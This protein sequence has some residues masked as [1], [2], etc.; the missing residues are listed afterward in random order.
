[1]AKT[2]FR[3]VGTALVTP[4]SADGSVDYE[5]LKELTEVQIA[6]GVN[7]I[8]ACGTTGE[9]STLRHDEHLKVIETIITTSAGRVPV[10]A[11][12]GSNDTLYTLELSEA[13]ERMGADALLMV[14]PYYNKTSQNGL[15]RHYEYVADRVNTPIILYNVPSR[16]G[17]DIKPETY[18]KLCKHPNIVATKEA[19]GNF[20]ALAQTIALCGDELDVYSGNDDQTVAMMAMGAK[21]VISVFSNLAPKIMAQLCQ[22]ALEGDFAGATAMQSRYLDVMNSMFIDVNP[23]PVKEAMNQLGLNVGECRMPLFPASD[24]VKEKIHSALV[25][26]QLL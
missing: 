24:D 9:K 3:G 5:K 17:M 20:S 10:V 1:M 19:N 14:T 13:A 21:G 4:F 18:A 6:G 26:A 8:I 25:K 2:I 7:A 23:I 12:T 11:G 16:T 15:I 22:K